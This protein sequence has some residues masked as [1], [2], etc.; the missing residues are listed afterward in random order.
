MIQ[1]VGSSGRG[2]PAPCGPASLKHVPAPGD[3]VDVLLGFPAPCGPA[4]LKPACSRRDADGGAV[5]FPAPCGPASLKPHT[6]VAH[7][8][9]DSIRFSGPLRAG[10]IE[11]SPR[12]PP[13][14]TRRRFSGPLRAGLIEAGPRRRSGLDPAR[15][16]PAPCGPA[17]L[18]LLDKSERIPDNHGFPAP[19]GPASLKPPD[20]APD[21][22]AL[23]GF[24]G[25]LRAGLIEAVSGTRWPGPRW[26][27]FRPLAGRP[28]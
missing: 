28:H 26:S 22:R 11:A 6:T 18:K 2:F 17:S 27:V 19:C 13:P 21:R 25:P 4:S 12:T 9:I 8:G 23:E 16:F 1:R 15:G 10:L 7:D 24:S 20:R 14:S 3:A 5:G